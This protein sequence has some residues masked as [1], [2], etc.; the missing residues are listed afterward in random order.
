MYAHAHIH[1]AKGL[2]LTLSFVD[3]VVP[4]TA[5]THGDDPGVSGLYLLSETGRHVQ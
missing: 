1:A 3:P 5:V 2:A 4:P